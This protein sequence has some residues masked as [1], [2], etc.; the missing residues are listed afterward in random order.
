MMGK[1]DDF[2]AEVART[3]GN[4]LPEYQRHPYAAGPRA[5]GVVTVDVSDMSHRDAL[6]TVKL[7]DPLAV[8][9][10]IFIPVSVARPTSPP[11]EA[12]RIRSLIA[13]GIDPF[14]GAPIHTKFGKVP[15]KPT[16]PRNER[17]RE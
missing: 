9:E 5:E 1:P 10:D 13:S 16:P 14:T 8:G 4:R 3:E 12:A 6:R 2:A 7:H 11:D 17:V 15:P